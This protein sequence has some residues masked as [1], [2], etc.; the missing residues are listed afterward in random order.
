MMKDLKEANVYP[1]LA[2]AGLAAGDELVPITDHN[3]QHVTCRHVAVSSH[4]VCHHSKDDKSRKTYFS[5][6]W[7]KFTC[8]HKKIIDYQFRTSA[9]AVVRYKTYITYI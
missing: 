4:S 2:A 7:L 3:T 8:Q 1:G 9:S 5:L 6:L